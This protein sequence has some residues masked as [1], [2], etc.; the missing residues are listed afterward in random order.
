MRAP[1]GTSC[2]RL[3]AAAA[4][5]GVAT[6]LAIGPSASAHRGQRPAAE[7]VLLLSVDGLHQSDLEWYVTNHPSSALA[8]L[9]HHGVEFTHAQTPVPVRL[10]PRAWSRQVDRR[11]PAAR[12]ASTTTTRW[13]RRPA[14]RR[15]DQLRGR[16]ARAPRSPTSRRSTRTCAQLDA[17]QGLTGLPGSIL[18]M[19]GNPDDADRPGAAARSTRQT[20]KPVYPHHYIKVNTIFE[21]ARSARAS[22]PRGRTSTPPTRSSTARPAPASRTSSPRR[23]TATRRPTAGERLD[24]RQRADRAVRRLQ[25]AGRPQRDR[26]LRPQRHDEAS[27]VPAIFGMNFQTV[28]TAE[29]LPTSDG[30]T[31][32]YLADGATPGPLLSRAR[33]TTSNAKVGG[34]GGGDASQRHLGSSTTI[35][36]S[37]KHGQS[38][39]RPVGAD[40]DRRRPDH[41]RRSTRPGRR[42]TPRRPRRWWRSRSTTTAMLI[43]LSDR[44]HGG[45]RFAKQLPARQ[46]TGPATT[47]TATRRP[48]PPRG[49]RRSTPA[50]TRRAT[51]WCVPQS[52]RACRT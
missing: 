30:L 49:W 42:R 15:D 40:A 5:A 8:A 10:V 28:S 6:A 47:S 24:D 2:R 38:P 41:R 27:D 25:G 37:A 16:R 17:G 12:R 51:S 52:T 33:W 36:L 14:A 29:K 31:G 4:V 20:C 50:R 1:S 32:G 35:I 18:Q 46:Q 13:N 34:D 7:H 39:T 19:T 26:R 3:L 23:S 44:S 45:D 22:A 21:V 48:T 43:W 9:T 11:Q